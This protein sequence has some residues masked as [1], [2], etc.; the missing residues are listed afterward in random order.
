VLHQRQLRHLTRERHP[1]PASGYLPG[2]CEERGE[3]RAGGRER[4]V[5]RRSL[6]VP[7]LDARSAHA[8]ISL[9]ITSLGLRAKTRLAT[10]QLPIGYYGVS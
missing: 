7:P 6:T 2:I 3:R 4:A 9:P 10:W 1:N 5:R 8:R